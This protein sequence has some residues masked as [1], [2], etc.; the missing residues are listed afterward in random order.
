MADT[1]MPPLR[2]AQRNA[3]RL[4]IE[5]DTWLVYELPLEFDR[6]SSP[7]LIFEHPMSVRRVR[8]YPPDWRTLTDAEL[9]ALSWTA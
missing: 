6:R 2:T 1:Q 5:G 7:S 9:I 3:R 8:N 4:I